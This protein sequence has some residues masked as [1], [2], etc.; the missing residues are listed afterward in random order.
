ML[1]SFLY[2][3][4]L[5]LLGSG[6]RPADERDIELLVLRHQLKVCGGK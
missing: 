1:F 6:R 3:L 2:F 4:L 5:Y